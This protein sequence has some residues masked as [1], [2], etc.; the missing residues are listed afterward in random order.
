MEV[1]APWARG[2]E[3]IGSGTS[4]CRH[5]EVPWLAWV[6]RHKDRR[7]RDAQD[8]VP[9]GSAPLRPARKTHIWSA[10]SQWHLPHCPVAVTLA[11]RRQGGPGHRQRPGD[12]VIDN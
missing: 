1:G 12:L 9:R 6:G 4:P 7:H 5:G 3:G 2:V 10:N 8:G 11:L